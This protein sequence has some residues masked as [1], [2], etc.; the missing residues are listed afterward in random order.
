MKANKILIIL[1]TIGMYVSQIPLYLLLTFFN[2]EQFQE[3]S[4]E[5]F[6]A[7]LIAIAVIA[8]IFIASHVFSAISIFKGD[9]NPGKVTMICKLALIP[10]YIFNFVFCALV[11]AGFLNP[12]LFLAIPVV[13]VIM[14]LTTYFYMFSM[15]LP[16]ICYFLNL[17]T[18]KKIKA[19]ALLIISVV[20]LF[21]F[22]LD[23]VGAII[24]YLKTK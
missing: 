5:C 23:P 22:C 21:I 2:M 4:D 24:Y 18:K 7:F 16:D 8:P 6:Y 19:D 17:V 12:F 3:Y 10:W 1:E 11:L 15:S 20:M 9:E 14:I 13:M